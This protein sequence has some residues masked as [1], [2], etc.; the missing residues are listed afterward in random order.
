MSEQIP[1]QFLDELPPK[2]I[3]KEDCA[4]WNNTRFATYFNDWLNPRYGTQALS[5]GTTKIETSPLPDK[6][7]SAAQEFA[8]LIKDKIQPQSSLKADKK[9]NSFKKH[10]PVHHKK[11]GTGIVQDVTLTNDGTVITVKFK[12]GVKKIVAHFLKAI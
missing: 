1:S 11:Y 6:K 12:S 9:S 3:T 4:Y 2:L 5:T 10:Q 8:A 7:E